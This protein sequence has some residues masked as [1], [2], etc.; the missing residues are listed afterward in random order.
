MEMQGVTARVKY[1]KTGLIRFIG[2]LDTARAFLRAVRRAGID[3]VYSQGFSP[4]LRLSFGPPLPLGLTS[5]CEYL[6][7]KLRSKSDPEAI[8]RSLREHLPE[9]LS[10]EEVRILEGTVP[11]LQVSFSAVEYEIEVPCALAGGGGWGGGG[12]QSSLCR[13]GTEF[14]RRVVS[15]SWQDTDCGTKV[16][17]LTLRED[18]PG[19]GRLKDVVG[20]LLGVGAGELVKLRIHKKR[21]FWKEEQDTR[22]CAGMTA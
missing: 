10:V 13:H 16:L 7:I 11:S 9:G 14:A 4:R 5:E 18:S 6:D 22:C 15:A 8:E 2:H 12:A 3:G 20:S 19:G 17:S 21:V 1:H